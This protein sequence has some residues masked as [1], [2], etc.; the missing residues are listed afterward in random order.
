MTEPVESLVRARLAEGA[1]LL[2]S[3]LGDECV[4]AIGAV[5]A[6]TAEAFRAGNKLLLFGNGGSAAD[7]IHVAAEFVGRYLVERRPLPAI[8]LVA[9]P[10]A[11]TAI[12]NDYGFE[13]VFARQ[14]T[15]LGAA[16]DVAIGFTTSGR[17]AN[18]VRGLEAARAAGMAT[19]AMTG[20]DP[21][22]VGAAAERVIRIPSADTP[23]VQEGQMLAAHIVCEWVEARLAEEAPPA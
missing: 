23:R 1:A 6:A 15:A 18:V 10:S 13:Q 2:E 4:A 20:A 11:V 9:N 22:P 7:A 19:V 3:M 12:G 14:V 21:G 17:S 16:G 5:A 8:A